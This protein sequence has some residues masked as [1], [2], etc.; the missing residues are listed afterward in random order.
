MNDKRHKD[1]EIVG[2]EEIKG[3][4]FRQWSMAL[5]DLS[6]TDPMVVMQH[7]EFDPYSVDREFLM[8]QIDDWIATGKPVQNPDS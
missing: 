2:F 1:V 6:D 5:I 7:P 4:R 8:Q 3:R